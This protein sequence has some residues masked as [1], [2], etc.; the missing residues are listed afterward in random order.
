MQKNA[1]LQEKVLQNAKHTPHPYK[2]QSIPLKKSIIF[3][4]SIIFLPTFATQNQ[5]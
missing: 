5:R 3:F 2:N 1:S 4:A